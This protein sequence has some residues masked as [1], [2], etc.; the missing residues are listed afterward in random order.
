MNWV[1]HYQRV[2][3]RGRWICSIVGAFALL[4]WIIPLLSEHV[5]H[6]YEA[7]GILDYGIMFLLPLLFVFFSI[8]AL[9]QFKVAYRKYNEDY[10]VFYNGFVKGHLIIDGEVQCVGGAFQYDFYGQLP[11]GTD[12]YVK[13]EKSGSVKFSIGQFNNTNIHHF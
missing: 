6:I 8:C 1:R 4:L 3:K 10:I 12:V 5:Y 7:H 11:D 9:C 2:A 13:Q